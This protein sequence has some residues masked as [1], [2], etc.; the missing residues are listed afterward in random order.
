MEY[1]IEGHT[2]EFK[3]SSSGSI[4]PWSGEYAKKIGVSQWGTS[5]MGKFVLVDGDDIYR[6]RWGEVLFSSFFEA[7]DKTWD[8]AMRWI[9]KNKERHFGSLKEMKQL[10]DER[11]KEQ[12]E[13]NAMTKEEKEK[14]LAEWRAKRDENIKKMKEQNDK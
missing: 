8:S 6:M 3:L 7:S 1:K 12:D 2:L 9:E 11:K 10:L 13:Y 5:D 14:Y 4:D